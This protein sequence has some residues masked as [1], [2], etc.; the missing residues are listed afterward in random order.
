MNLTSSLLTD[1]LQLPYSKVYLTHDQLKLIHT[2]LWALPKIYTYS[3]Q[4]EPFLH[5]D[6]DV[7]LFHPFDSNLM[8]SELIAQNVEVAT[9]LKHINVNGFNVF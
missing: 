3:L 4:K 7:F 6:G 5:I 9:E 2:D 1:T 8:E